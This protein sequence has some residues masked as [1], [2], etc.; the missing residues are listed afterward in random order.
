MAASNTVICL[1]GMHRSGTSCLAGS[2]ESR[3]LVLGD[4]ERVSPFNC[5]G[6]RENRQI[7]ELN[8]AVLAYS[9]GAWD[10][11]PDQLSWDAAL[12]RRRDDLLAARAAL[13][14]WGFKDPRTTLTL[15]FWLE[16]RPDLVL[17]GSFRNPDAVERSVMARPGAVPRRPARPLW[18]HYN[19]LLADLAASRELRLLCFDWPAE[20]YGRAVEQLALDLGLPPGDG[21]GADFFE[22]S[23]RHQVCRTGGADWSLVEAGLYQRLLD[24]ACRGTDG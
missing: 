10:V 9:G 23:L 3:G 1:L 19:A 7:V 2:L 14:C 8:D 6:N 13:A 4:V 5:R 17:A 16:A 22:E 20:Q 11:P 21:T 18:A 15:P 12:R 24:L